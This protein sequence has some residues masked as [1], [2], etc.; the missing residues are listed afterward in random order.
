[1]K[2]IDQDKCTLEYWEQW[3]SPLNIVF[4]S[5]YFSG[6]REHQCKSHNWGCCRAYSTKFCRSDRVSSRKSFRLRPNTTL[7]HPQKGEF[8]LDDFTTDERI[9]IA[10]RNQV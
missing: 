9:Q 6:I 3:A 4:E 10:S 7:Q 8:L 1:M 2:Y 5:F